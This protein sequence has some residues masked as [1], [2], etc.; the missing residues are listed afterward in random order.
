MRVPPMDDVNHAMRTKLVTPVRGWAY[1][2]RHAFDSKEAFL[3]YVHTEGNAH[4]A[5]SWVNEDLKPSP[6]SQVNWRWYNFCIFW[7]GMGFGN[8]SESN[9]HYSAGC[10]RASS[11]LQ[12][13][14]I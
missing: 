1:R 2:L 12:D 14:R 3:S 5:H 11:R 9:L 6:P 4:Q 7:F 8:W 13:T 10:S